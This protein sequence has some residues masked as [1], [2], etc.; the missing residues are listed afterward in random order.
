MASENNHEHTLEH[1]CDIDQ[2]TA[3]YNSPFDGDGV[4]PLQ[5]IELPQ[6][7][8]ADW[9]A[10]TV[11][12]NYNRVCVSGWHGFLVWLELESHLATVLKA[13]PLF[14]SIDWTFSACHFFCLL[15]HHS[16]ALVRPSS[17]HLSRPRCGAFELPTGI[18]AETRKGRK[19]PQHVCRVP[20]P[21]R[22]D[23]RAGSV[24]ML[25][26]HTGFP[27]TKRARYLDQCAVH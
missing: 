13:N 14:T 18:V 17:T 6:R 24:P 22:K 23:A 3:T 7:T 21:P 5:P 11:S 8:P 1:G 15:T 20:R 12:L 16:L 19:H 27:H 25:G 9:V 4:D 2:S 26:T 10:Y